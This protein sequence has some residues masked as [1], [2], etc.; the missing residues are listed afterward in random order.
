[1]S[2]IGDKAQT[3]SFNRIA[4]GDPG[5]SSGSVVGSPSVANGSR[6]SSFHVTLWGVAVAISFSTVRGHVDP[7]RFEN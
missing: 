7:S 1:V 3:I 6:N 4:F 5:S 2:R